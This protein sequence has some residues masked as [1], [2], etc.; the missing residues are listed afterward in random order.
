[1]RMADVRV[2]MRMRLRGHPGYPKI[3][4]TELTDKGFRYRLDFPL[5]LVPRWG[6][7][8]EANG[9]EHFG[10][11]DGECCFD[12]VTDEAPSTVALERDKTPEGLAQRVEEALHIF[13]P[14]RS[15]GYATLLDLVEDLWQTR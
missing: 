1:M 12:L 10:T 4:V 14:Q 3:T 11:A 9:H 2:G 15:M 13:G 6:M 7:I 8:I 5:P